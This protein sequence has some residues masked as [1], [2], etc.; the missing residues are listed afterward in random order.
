MK[1][2]R[3]RD[4]GESFIRRVVYTKAE[5]DAKVRE[6]WITVFHMVP[7][8]ICLLILRNTIDSTWGYLPFIAMVGIT[9]NYFRK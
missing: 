9:I 5:W 2:L 4:S 8:F 1:I 3:A 6:E 7:M